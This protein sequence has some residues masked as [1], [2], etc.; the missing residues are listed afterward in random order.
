MCGI[1]KLNVCVHACTRAHTHTHTHT[2]TCFCVKRKGIQY[3]VG[4][5]PRKGSS[6]QHCGHMK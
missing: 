1:F 5:L 2:H 4:A 3:K 6:D